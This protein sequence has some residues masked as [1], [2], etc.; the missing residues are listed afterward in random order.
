MPSN[1]D[2]SEVGVVGEV[3]EYCE[4]RGKARGVAV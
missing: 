3:E 2:C 4:G 1:A